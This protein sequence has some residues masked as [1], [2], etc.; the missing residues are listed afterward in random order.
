MKPND[1]TPAKGK[2]K[3]TDEPKKQRTS[4]PSDVEPTFETFTAA[5]IQESEEFLSQPGTPLSENITISLPKR[6]EQLTERDKPPSLSST[7]SW[8]GSKASSFSGVDSLSVGQ[9]SD[10]QGTGLGTWQD[11]EAK[12][13]KEQDKRKRRIQ[14]ENGERGELHPRLLKYSSQTRNN[15]SSLDKGSRDRV[16]V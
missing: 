7:V 3:P 11:I 2:A 4:D 6:E 16:G 1:G 15:T 8:V 10:G 14:F 5:E 12:R 13:R 9:P